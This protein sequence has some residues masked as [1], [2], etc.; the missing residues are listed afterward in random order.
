MT[1]PSATP[2]IDREAELGRMRAA[3]DAALG[4]SGRV[5][6]LAGEPGIGKTRLAS[7]LADEAGARGVPVWW[8][9]GGEDGSA[10]AFWPWNAALRGWIDRTGFDGV[11]EAGG[12]WLPDLAHVFPVLRE[13]IPDVPASESSESE[14]AR[15]RLLD[16][17]G[18][19]LGA[20]A[21]RAGLVVVLDDVHWADGPSLRL[22]EFVAS[23]LRDTRVLVV[24]TYRDNEVRRED[25]FFSTLSRLAREPSTRRLMLTG[26][27]AAHCARWGNPCIARRTATRSSSARS[28][29]SSPAKKD[30]T[31][32][33]GASRTGFARSSRAVSIGSG[34]RAPGG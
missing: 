28:S 22:L 4:G 7:V 31:R 14:R 1:D 33:P 26:L 13:R 32:T 8:G 5:A 34:G 21:A 30:S 24:A 17:V 29:A 2:F 16:L 15:F 12:S 25:A 23:G 20:V 18:C 3:L 27:S 11:V 6:L 9:R 19:F 10:P